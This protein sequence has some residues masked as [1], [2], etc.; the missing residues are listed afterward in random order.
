MLCS[1]CH[2]VLRREIMERA[3]RFRTGSVVFD[4]RRKTWNLLTWEAG[5]RRTQ[6][7]GTL[8]EYRSKTAAQRAAQS[9]PRTEIPQPQ[10]QA[11]TIRVL[12]DQYRKEKM[13]ERASTRRGYETYLQNQILP[14]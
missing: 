4:R 2:P 13:P 12:V 14:K 11:G 3:P 8:S 10:P 5:K 7:I 1:I 6:R 9:I